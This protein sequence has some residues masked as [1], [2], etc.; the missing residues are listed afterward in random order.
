MRI[1]IDSGGTF[2][3]FAV[4]RDD[5]SL[6][7]FKLRSN[8]ADPASVI[9]E[10]IERVRNGEAANVVHGSTVATN[11][12]LERKGARTA[13]VAS[14]GFR[15][16]LAIGRQNRTA[17]Y[18]LHPPERVNLV[19][20]KLSFEW[21]GDADALRHAIE[22]SDAEAVAIC[23]LHAYLDPAEE[24][25]VEQALQAG[26]L[27]L[28]RSSD[29]A[30]EFREYERASTTVLNAYVG[31][32]MSRYLTRLESECPFP[33]QIMQSNGGLLSTAAAR[34]HAV[35]TILSG[36]A[37]GVI[38]ARGMAQRAGWDKSIAFDMGGTSTDVSVVESANRFATEAWIEGLPVRVPMLDIH[39][40]GAGGGSLASVDAGGRLRV[41]PESA[42]SRPGPACYGVG[43]QA[44]VTD[45]HV[46][47]GRILPERFL[48][49][50]MPIDAGRAE[51]AVEEIS[52]KLNVT[53]TEAA[54]AI[55]R[56]AN[57]NMETALR[58]VT[59]ERGLDPR[60]FPLVAFG[61][62]GGLHACEI[63]EELG[64]ERVIFP[65]FAG[66]LSA[67]GMLLAQP[68]RDY[69][70]GA[71]GHHAPGDLFQKLEKQALSEM[72]VATLEP[73]ADIRYEGQSFELTV[74]WK[75][76]DPRL[77]FEQ[78]YQQI[79]GFHDPG[80]PIEIVTVRIRATLPTQA[81]F[82]LSS[83]AAGWSEGP[84]GARK[85]SHEGLEGPALLFDYGATVFIPPGWRIERSSEAELVAF[86]PA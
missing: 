30:P 72:P 28:S 76:E 79:Y 46:V 17:L 81:T 55:V 50:S 68:T 13:F 54:A 5:G 45:A 86:K 3:D 23:L 10:G 34:H 19:P 4:L 62:C 65:A 84:S 63:A 35:R 44:T 52:I 22:E 14:P 39:T 70:A 53:T 69:A 12:L 40:V 49:G 67:L 21:A 1:G 26:G 58:A 41:G 24:L 29:V 75:P 6:S 42:G 37:G 36:P 8:P 27:Y 74:P 31:P 66:A 18:S 48:D 78:A 51:R 56:I 57:S 7:V 38:G 61:G 16:L 32:L 77:E 59:V 20:R 47:L 80:R 9:L 60:D 15:D 25:K 82:D 83:Q 85:A 11:A 71:L 2:T 73:Y 64:I 33:I 43:E